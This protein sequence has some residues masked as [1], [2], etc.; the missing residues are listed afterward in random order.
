MDYTSTPSDNQ[1]PNDHDYQQLETIYAHLDSTTTLAAAT[2]SAAQM[3]RHIAEH[4]ADDPSG[5]GKLIRSSKDGLKE[6]YMLDFG[7]GYRIFRFVIWAEGERR[8]QHSH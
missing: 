3:P 2:A 4:D 7:Q 6:V 8:G 1:H 5:W